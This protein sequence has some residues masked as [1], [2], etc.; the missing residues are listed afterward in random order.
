PIAIA[1]RREGTGG[2]KPSQIILDAR[3]GWGK[4]ERPF[5]FQ[6]RLFHSSHLGKT[7]AKVEV[8]ARVIRKDLERFLEVNGCQVGLALL[9]ER[10]A[11][12]RA[13]RHE[14]WLGLQRDFVPGYRLLWL[15]LESEGLAEVKLRL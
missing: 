12:A 11:Q 3:I 1:Q 4:V 7:E 6:L 9:Q 15:S 5:V 14:A 10:I 2:Q 8:Q 13:R